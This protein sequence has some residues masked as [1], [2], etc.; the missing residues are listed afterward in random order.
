MNEALNY[1]ISATSKLIRARELSPVELVKA[2]IERIRSNESSLGSYVRV[3][4]DAAIE[5]ARSAENEIR[6][7]RWRGPLHGIPVAV[8]DLFDI[9]G[10][11][12]TAS[13]R[14]RENWTPEADS[15]VVRRLKDAGAIIVGKTHTHEF[16]YGVMTPSTRN[17]WDLARTPGGSS[18]GSGSTVAARQCYMAMGTDT[19]GSIRIP[20]AICGTVGLKP[21]F[22]R[23]SRAGVTPLSWS[24]DHAGPLTRTV[25]DAAISLAV[26][27]GHDAGDPASLPME[28]FAH[29]WDAEG[30][31]VEGLRIGVPENYFVENVDEEVLGAVTSACALLESRGAILK[32]VR[33]PMVERFMS[34]YFLIQL[35][36]ASAYHRAMMRQ[37]PELYNEDVRSYLEAG[38]FVF[39]SDYVQ[40]QRARSLIKQEFQRLFDDV[41]VII[42]P[43]VPTVAVPA[44]LD[45]ISWRSGVEESVTMAY[46]RFTV[47]G[48]LT[49]MP[50]ISLPCG[51]SSEGLPIGMQIMGRP[52][53]EAVLLKLASCYES[54]TSWHEQMPAL[55]GR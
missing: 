7:D 45:S 29:D 14:Q 13:S 43:T 21:T 39:A 52:L 3:L 1:S 50:A 17:P 31:N 49:G 28:S 37:S 30:A 5:E 53:D 54:M 55:V 44:D 2:S 42:S 47:P 4:E 51:F 26:L 12:T 22:G 8:K 19:G 23:V 40:A 35:P 9:K 27:A 38:E 16:A 10:V 11:P 18:G 36:E 32:P 20:A 34:V 25:D 46:I 6:S 33:I 48:D 41:D 24:F 15:T